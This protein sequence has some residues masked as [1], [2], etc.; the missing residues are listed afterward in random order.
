MLSK[1]SKSA[2]LRA[3]VT[4]SL[5][6]VHAQRQLFDGKISS[7][8]AK[9]FLPRK[10]VRA[11]S[12][13]RNQTHVL[14]DGSRVATYMKDKPM[15]TQL[16]A[17]VSTT[18][19]TVR[20]GLKN[21]G[22]E[23][24]GR[25]VELNGQ[26]VWEW[27]SYAEVIE[28]SDKL[29]QAFRILGL[30]EGDDVNIGIYSR[31]CPEWTI[32]EIAVHNFSNVSVPLYDTVLKKDLVYIG[33]LTELELVLVDTEQRAK[34]LIDNVAE[35]PHLK[36]VVIFEKPSENLRKLAKNASINL[37]ALD[38]MIELGAKG[39]LK[40]CPPSPETVASITFTSGTTGN[41]KGAV[42]THKNLIA[43][44]STAIEFK[45]LEHVVISY[46]PLAH[47]Y[48]RVLEL[49]AFGC[50]GKVGYYRG[51]ITKLIDD[52]KSLKPTFFP[53]VPRVMN[54][55]HKQIILEA[56][57]SPIKHSI[58]K[59]VIAWKFFEVK[60]HV[61]RNDSILDKLFLTKI[62]DILGGRV[63][64]MVVAAA[65]PCDE[66]LRFFRAA[67]G[68]PVM[69]G[70]GQTENAGAAT[71]SIFVDSDDGNVGIPVPCNAVKLMDEPDIGYF[72]EKNGGQV[73]IKGPNVMRGY[74]KDP[75]NTKKTITEEGWLKTGDIGRWSE[76]G[77][78]EIVDRMKSIVKLTQGKF[79][80]PEHLESIY[81]QSEFVS[82]IYVHGDAKKSCLV[83][84]IVPEP[85]YLTTFAK[86]TYGLENKS[87]EELCTDDRIRKD[88]VKALREVAD[89]HTDGALHGYERIADVFLTPRPFTVDEV[90]LTPTQKNKRPQ[91]AAHFKNQI[92]DIKML[93]KGSR[94][95]M[96]M[97]SRMTS[98]MTQR[99]HFLDGKLIAVGA[100]AIAASKI[101]TSPKI[102]PICDVN[103]QTH[104]LEDGSRIAAH[105]KGYILMTTIDEGLSTTYEM[106]RRGL[107]NGGSEMLGRRVE[108][109]GQLVW[110]WITYAQAIETADL[111]SQG[112]R[113]LGIS[114][115][116]ETNIGIFSQNRPEWVI[117]EMAIHNFSNA[118]V[119]LYDTV[120]KDDL[121]YICNLTQL[122][123]ILVDK[124]ERAR[125]IIDNIHHIP[126]MK[127]IVL[128]EKPSANFQEE[129][130]RKMVNLL[131]FDELAEVGKKTEIPHIKPTSETVAS[132]TFT[133]G[134]TGKPKGVILTHGNLV[135]EMTSS[136]EFYDTMNQTVISYLPLA[137]IYERAIEL[138]CFSIGGRVGYFRGDVTQL[139]DDVKSLKP[140]VFPMVPRVMNKIHKKVMIEA[141]KSPVKYSILRAVLAWKQLEL[142]NGIV[143]NDGLIDKIFLRKIHEALGGQVK[144]VI[145]GSAAPSDD[146]VRFTRCAF[147]CV[148]VVGY[149]QTE[150]SAA[151]TSSILADMTD[152]HV[153]VPIPSNAVKL[154]D[155]PELG[156]YV[157][158]NG[159]E[160]LIKGK[161]V[162]RG[163]YK[164]PK[165]TKEAL[166]DEGWLKTGDIGKWR[167]N[168]TLEI[169]D[170]KK[171]IVKLSQGKFVA[172][173]HLE[174]IYLLSDFVA[175]IYIHADM[176][177]SSLV[178]VIVP[179]PV[180]L[181]NFA[182]KKYGL[183]SLT[184]EE[185]CA[186]E[187]LKEDVLKC[188]RQV[189]DAN[190]E[191]PLHGYERIADVFLAPHSFS[192]DDGLV[193]PTQKNRR[194]QLA[195]FYKKPIAQMYNHLNRKHL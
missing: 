6:G 138:I 103:Q 117:G 139:I 187:R 53:M 172:P 54:K 94:S 191:R 99:R 125:L 176:K 177:Q 25:R 90:L 1:C 68:C 168:G 129:A 157:S 13:P 164:D 146:A 12:C 101:L 92:A 192:I 150:T 9:K 84:V 69:V 2:I 167:E 97:A 173:E 28:K 130:K 155:V 107:R 71:A 188:L 76:K 72:V 51:D 108:I 29:S 166:D 30:K 88:V 104:V 137:H 161:N 31:N 118:S 160:I 60:N 193:T 151:A 178:A 10:K 148:V 4:S 162:T 77:V 124:E 141:K 170:R 83:A 59:A 110:E 131:T 175:Q 55:L 95:T 186:D 34:M 98:A 102:H 27:M 50:A 86:T 194:P 111:V 80:A 154:I 140:T 183:Q 91:M 149:G 64:F 19:E 48:E 35:L 184:Y 49:I 15:Q 11:L 62:R 156:Y 43:D 21:G 158:K 63:Q 185:L 121:I 120:P 32:S 81:Q 26:L 42:L 22:K 182:E 66:A 165:A 152:G 70:Y 181:A 163:Y 36:H 135:A 115:G 136:F 3:R 143:R 147:G 93:S 114:T 23:M 46:L 128:F 89:N 7:T 105:R 17:G 85:T 169:V 73:M 127:N 5:V 82:Q 113:A 134:T 75:T 144:M 119:P 190:P 87:L 179:D 195:E 38:E 112:F 65:A 116:D 44:T 45:H 37:L 39:T 142:K 57:K 18:Y 96:M 132:I 189:A 20:N 56:Q 79:V 174:N 126:L 47:I 122:S 145:V 61:I 133:S 153:G 33:K 123:T 171:S 67:F 58:L 109:D 8:I 159:G 24:L 74:Y 40:H 106:M 180:Y 41:P 14:E 78:L 16:H 100:A 52:A